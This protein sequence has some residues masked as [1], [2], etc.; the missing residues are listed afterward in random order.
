[1]IEVKISRSKN[2]VGP[3]HI[4]RTFHAGYGKLVATANASLYEETPM[5][6][7]PQEADA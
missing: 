4:T 2:A 7:D 3:D 1:M 6:C 5:E